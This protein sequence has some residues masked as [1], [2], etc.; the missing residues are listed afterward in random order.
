MQQI[1]EVIADWME[2]T[3]PKKKIIAWLKAN[4]GWQKEMVIRRQIGQNRKTFEPLMRELVEEGVVDSHLA[5]DHGAKFY[6]Y[7]YK[8]VAQKPIQLSLL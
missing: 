1:E 4:K 2:E 6:W 7:K 5:N 3:Y 8:E